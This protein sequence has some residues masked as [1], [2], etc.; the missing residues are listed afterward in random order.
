MKG[1]AV[2]TEADREEEL[3]LGG[4]SEQKRPLWFALQQLL[5]LKAV[6]HT[7][8]TGAVVDLEEIRDQDVVSVAATTLCPTMRTRRVPV[9]KAG[10]SRSRRAADVVPREGGLWW[11]GRGR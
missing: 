3:I 7:P 2:A 5:C 8:V 9:L 4:V 11:G 10:A 1:A 6:Q